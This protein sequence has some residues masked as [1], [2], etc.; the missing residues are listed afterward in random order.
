M[1]L[2]QSI[3]NLLKPKREKEREEEK[4]GGVAMDTTFNGGGGGHKLNLIYGYEGPQAVPARP[5]L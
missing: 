3:L 4:V 2:G 5:S 1:Q